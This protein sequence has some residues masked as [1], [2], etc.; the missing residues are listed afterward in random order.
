MW[1]LAHRYTT[2]SA[3][4]V[5]VCGYT[6]YPVLWVPVYEYT[7][8][9]LSGPPEAGAGLHAKSCLSNQSTIIQKSLYIIFTEH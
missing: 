4:W 3:L 6:T 8:A 9:V 7:S 2:Y 5:L 1:A